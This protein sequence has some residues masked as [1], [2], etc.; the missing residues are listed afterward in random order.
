MKFKKYQIFIDG[1]S[2]KEVKN[3]EIPIEKNRKT[4]THYFRKQNWKKSRR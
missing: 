4:R 2:V 1:Q 3:L